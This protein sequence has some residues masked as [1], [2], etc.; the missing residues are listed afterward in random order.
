M[1]IFP[2]LS[3]FLVALLCAW[4]INGGAADTIPD[5]FAVLDHRYQELR[6]QLGSNHFQKPIYVASEQE[7]DKVSA[8][9]YAVISAGFEQTQTMLSS[10]TSWC[11][12]LF[13]HLN[14]KS[15]NVSETG[16][17][18]I[19]RLRI[20]KKYNQPVEDAYELVFDYRVTKKSSRYLS[21]AL[22]AP[23]GPFGTRDYHVMLEAIPLGNGKTFLHLSY[24][25]RYGMMGRLAMQTYFATL[26]RNKVG[27]TVTDTTP[28]SD[29]VYVT[30][31]RGLVERNTMRYYL[32]IESCLN[33]TAGSPPVRLERRLRDWFAS[34]ER[35]PRQLHEIELHEYLDM[36]HNESGR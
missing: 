1:K 20:G 10:A 12:I 30:G 33:N 26:A 2:L 18:T 31:M 24:A 9:I 6:E 17:R 14:T 25:Y 36:K 34:T 3:K 15:C 29:P 11:D 22:D 19:L 28:R 35:Y 27:F 21:A 13:L 4:S 16:Y 7:K 32:A 8:D 23:S 5:N